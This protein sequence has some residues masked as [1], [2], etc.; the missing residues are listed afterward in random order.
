MNR[1]IRL[2][3]VSL[4]VVGIAGVAMAAEETAAPVATTAPAMTS[5]PAATFVSGEVVSVDQATS[6][7]VVKVVKDATAGTYENTT[8]TVAPETKITK[9]DATLAISDLKAGDKV[10]V[11]S[12]ADASGKAMVESI[13]VE[14]VK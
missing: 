14:A 2:A 13:A 5:A 4:I 7:V 1:M 3:I 9:G 11:K 12:T 10:T 8:V 6:A